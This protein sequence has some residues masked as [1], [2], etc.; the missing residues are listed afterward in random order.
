MTSFNYYRPPRKRKYSEASFTIGGSDSNEVASDT[1]LA[2]T[3]LM[4]VEGREKKTRGRPPV[5]RRIITPRVGTQGMA[6]TT[7]DESAT[8]GNLSDAEYVAQMKY[9]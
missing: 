2:P 7:D 5:G 1:Q 4:L 3:I 9:R 8:D 6:L